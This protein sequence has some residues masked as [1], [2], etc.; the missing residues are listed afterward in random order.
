MANDDLVRR[1][2]DA[3]RL[4]FARDL[5]DVLGHTLCALALKG[6]LARVF[7]RSQP[8][9]AE[10]Q[11]GEMLGLVRTAHQ[12][13]CEVVTRYREVSLRSE[14]EGASAVLR[15]A[16][17]RSTVDSVALE[18]VPRLAAVPLAYAVRE[19]ATNVLRHTAATWCRITLGGTDGAWGL[20]MVNDGVAPTGG[21]TEGTGNGLR[22]LRERLAA[23]HGRLRCGPIGD[24]RYELVVSVPGLDDPA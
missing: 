12:E 9:V 3:E 19:G 5:H 4:R 1:A 17:I 13:I 15:S 21:T 8:E 22:G 23:A 11:L 18:A 24:G 20:R 7:L 10:H 2:V 6:E 16:G 14:L